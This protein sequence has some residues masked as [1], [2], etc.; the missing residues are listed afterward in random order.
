MD[1]TYKL[2]NTKRFGTPQA[3]AAKW[4]NENSLEVDFN[5]FSSNHKYIITIDFNGKSVNWN[6]FD[7]AGF[8]DRLVFKAKRKDK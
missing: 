6:M 2:S 4:I 3:G 5:D 8:G 1:G 7:E